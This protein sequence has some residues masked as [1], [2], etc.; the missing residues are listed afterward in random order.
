MNLK[1]TIGYRAEWGDCLFLHL[2]FSAP[3]GFQESTELQ[4]TTL[5]GYNWTA[6]TAP[7][8]N[9][10]HPYNALSYHYYVQDGGGKV[11]RRECLLSPRDYEYDASRNY[12]FADAWMVDDSENNCGFHMKQDGISLP[13]IHPNHLPLFEQ[14]IV[15]KV[16]APK[17][18]E[19][20]AIALLGNHPTLGNWNT[21]HFLLMKPARGKSWELSVDVQA[22]D[23]PIEYKYVVVDAKTH[24]FK[25]WE[26]G[27]N[28]KIGDMRVY[29]QEVCVLH[30]GDFHIKAIPP[31]A[32]F[33]FDTYIFDLDG[34]LL[35]TLPDL[36]ASCNFALKENGMPA[37]SID[38]VRMFV[39]NGVKKLMERAVPGGLANRNFEKA[40]Q[41]FRKHY[42]IHNLDT[43]QP[44]PDVIEML[45]DLKDR[46]K[47]VAV[48][49]NKFY[50]ATQELCHHFFGHLVDVAIGEREGIQKKPAPD[51]VNEALRQLHADRAKSVYI[52]DSDVDVMTARNSGMPCISVLWGFRDQ[53]FLAAH[54]ATIFV[55][56]PLQLL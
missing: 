49:S 12:L 32:Q 2:T 20:E 6:D 47:N 14:T 46:G 36:A 35:S 17:L 3:D 8:L 50:A 40:Y 25:R 42:M 48:V 26:F 28:R 9:R 56:S 44:Y 38:E 1:F 34:T 13:D 55:S 51:T 27:E 45:Q 19:G 10:H 15:F 24:Q 5:D 7:H 4:M 11:K 29:N 16:H 31:H 52:G 22:I 53:D 41:D 18:Y 30:G 43:T 33:N 39:G 54:D 21:D 23:A 37:R